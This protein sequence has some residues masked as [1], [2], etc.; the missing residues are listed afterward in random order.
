M[1][2]AWVRNKLLLVDGFWYIFFF[3]YRKRGVFPV[4]ISERI[5]N[6]QSV[7]IS[8]CMSKQRKLIHDSLIHAIAFRLFILRLRVR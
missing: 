8:Y 1:S 5:C 4:I 7:I 3:L 6:T 2:L